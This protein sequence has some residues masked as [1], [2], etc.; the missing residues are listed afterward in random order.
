LEHATLTVLFRALERPIVHRI[1]EIEEFPQALNNSQMWNWHSRLF[2]TEARQNLTAEEREGTTGRYTKTELDELEKTLKEHE[3]WLHEWV[4]KRKSIPVNHDPVVDTA[5]MRK[6][7][8][9]LETNLQRLV[10]K[11][12]PRVRASSSTSTATK[13]PLPTDET[14]PENG[15]GGPSNLKHDVHDEL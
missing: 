12:P 9:T 4:E 13:M 14:E 8:K 15:E 10:Q 3:T 1:K 11:K 7:A 6:R 5:E 2:L